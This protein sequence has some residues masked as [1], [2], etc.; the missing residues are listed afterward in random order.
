MTTSRWSNIFYFSWTYISSLPRDLF[1]IFIFWANR[2]I[3]IG[4]W[5]V[6]V[7]IHYTWILSNELDFES[8]DKILML[9]ITFDSIWLDRFK[10]GITKCVLA[11]RVGETVLFLII[12]TQETIGLSWL[13]SHRVQALSWFHIILSQIPILFTN[14][15][16]E[17]SMSKLFNLLG[18]WG[19]IILIVVHKCSLELL[20]VKD[21]VFSSLEAWTSF[22]L[23][24]V[25][26]KW[27]CLWLLVDHS[28]LF[29]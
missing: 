5:D 24:T 19:W 3:C 7:F 29:D 23:P 8:L 17:M 1:F 2:F 16:L 10:Q 27:E 18:I 6:F 9:I 12:L 11:F 4:V 26:N 25:L 20:E 13:L 15:E 28:N 22:D 14:F 21:L